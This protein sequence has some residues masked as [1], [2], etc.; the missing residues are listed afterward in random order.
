[1]ATGQVR[2]ALVDDRPLFCRG[3]QLLLPAVTAERVQVAGSTDDATAAAGLVRRC[4]PDL[5]LV[6]LA[7]PPP[8]GVRAIGAIRRTE[9]AVPVVAMSRNDEPGLGVAALR[10]GA[11]GL[12]PTAS[13]PEDL[14]APLL[15][16]VDGYAVL[17]AAVLA[18]LV[19]R[20]GPAPG[21]VSRLSAAERELWR[22]VATGE[23]T[24]RIALR[25]HVSERTAKRLVA[26]LLRQLRV[27]S[28]TEAAALAGRT[29]LL[30]RPA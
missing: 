28:R 20:S 4:Q 29:G 7:L 25:L 14:V 15:S 13:E 27:S 3:L 12:V 30:D 16:V 10:A 26:A 17:P 5:V 24:T 21:A 2:L 23:S 18:R 9:P 6:D 1:M 8:G 11:T 19:E 22:L